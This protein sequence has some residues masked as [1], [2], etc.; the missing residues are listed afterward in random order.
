MVNMVFPERYTN[1]LVEQHTEFRNRLNYI[2]TT[3][4]LQ[5]YKGNSMEKGESFQQM[6]LEQL[7]IHMQQKQKQNKTNN[8]EAV[9]DDCVGRP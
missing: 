5:N 4:Y 9:Q 1:T 3:D 6:V 2:Y 7:D 8:Q